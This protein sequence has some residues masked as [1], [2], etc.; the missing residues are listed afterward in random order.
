MITIGT[1]TISGK[2]FRIDPN[3][4]IAVIGGSG[5]GKSSL[6]ERIFASFVSKKGCGGAF[7]DPHGDSARKLPLMVS[8]SRRRDIIY[9]DPDGDCPQF[10]PLYFIDLELLEQAKESCITVLK[11]LSGSDTA[12]GNLTPYNVRNGLD[13]LTELESLCT[14]VHLMHFLASEKYRKR[15]LRK[16]ADPFV[17]LYAELDLDQDAFTAAINKVA[18]LMRPNILSVI[19]WPE[20]LDLLECMNSGKIF[21]FRLSKGALGE[22]TAQILYSLIISM[23]SIAA[24]KRESQAVRPP[25]LIVAD[26]AQNA[27]A[28]GRMGV[29]LA[30]ARKYGI[31]LCIAQQGLY[32][33]PLRDDILTNAATQIVFNASGDDAETMA[34]NWNEE[35]THAFD[36]TDLPRY[37]F[38]ARTFNN[39]NNPNVKQVDALPAPVLNFKSD[40]ERQATFDSIVYQSKRRYAIPRGDIQAK[41]KEILAT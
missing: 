7:F 29:L 31:S 30:E 3:R 23:F 2:P 18:K 13:V 8:Q 40:E 9:C 27:T 22:E 37:R 12:W 16:T 6:L 11:S 25:F 24:L 21:I 38:F 15:L 10:N 35:N 26:E 19:G 36:I 4:H 20:S 28:G 33:T 17:K 41:I 5:V 1:E 34:K 32:Q 39:S 14:L